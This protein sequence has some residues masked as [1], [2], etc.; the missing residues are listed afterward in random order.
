[1]LKIER[2]AASQGALL[3]DLRCWALA[4]APYAFSG[5]LAEA[6]GRSDES[7]AT[8]AAHLAHDQRSTTFI[9]YYNGQPCGMM[10][11]YL[12]GENDNTANLVAVWVAPECR[13]LKVG[14][15]LLEAIKGW[16]RESNAQVLHAWVAEQ[17]LSAIGFYKSAGFQV[18]GER[19]PFKSDASQEEILL[20]L[21]L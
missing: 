7:W 18:S 3:K 13:K 11:C 15:G 21:Q 12:L 9:G 10:G 14:Q 4:D 20:T 6:A 19:Q 17:N 8:S 5:T 16:A 1:M 2:I